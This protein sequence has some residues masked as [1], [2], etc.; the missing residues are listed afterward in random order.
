MAKLSVVIITF[1]EEENLPRCLESARWADEIVIVDTFSQDRTKEIASRYTDKI[2]D[3]K[4]PGFGPAKQFAME[5]ASCQWVL[6]LDADEVVSESLREEIKRITSSA[7][8]LDGYYLPRLSN[9]LGKWIRYGGWYPDYVLRLFKK[10]KGKFADSL[11]HEQLILNGRSAILKEALLH[12]TDPDLER[13]L[14]KLNRYTTL[15]AQELFRD[16][17][18]AGILDIAVRPLAIFLKMYILKL[19]FLDGLQGLLLAMFSSFHVL[20][21]YAKLWHLRQV[22]R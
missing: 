3:L 4:W 7:D 6:S 5:K 12:Y 13:Y 10:E 14:T 19:G 15:S 17:N 9:F 1:N 18:R 21:K 22:N 20:T 2:Y 8:A 11:V 16:D